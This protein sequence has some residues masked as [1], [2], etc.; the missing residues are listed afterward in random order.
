MNLSGANVLIPGGFGGA[1]I[2]I[3]HD[4]KY[5]QEVCGTVYE[6]TEEGLVKRR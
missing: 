5:R 2:S 3:S 1:V 4:G 6:M